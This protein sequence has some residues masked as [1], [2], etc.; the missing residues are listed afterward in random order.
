MNKLLSFI[1]YFLT[2]PIVSIY[3][4]IKEMWDLVTKKKTWVMLWAV[5]VGV[6]LIT[7]NKNAFLLFA[8]LFII[9]LVVFQWQTYNEKYI[10]QERLRHGYSLKKR[11][12]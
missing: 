1:W 3:Q 5:L 4:E 9:F 11:K 2:D 10:N 7:K 6:A 8:I 12:D